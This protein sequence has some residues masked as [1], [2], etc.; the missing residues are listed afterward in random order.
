MALNITLLG[1][2]I[3]AEMNLVSENDI[4]LSATNT[5]NLLNNKQSTIT[6]SLEDITTSNLSS[7]RPIVT[8][9]SSKFQGSNFNS[10]LLENLNNVSTSIQSQIDEKLNI[11]TGAISSIVNNSLTGNKI[12]VS[13]GGKI[14]VSTIDK[15]KFDFLSSINSNIKTQIEIRT[16]LLNNINNL[17]IDS[18]NNIVQNLPPTGI[19]SIVNLSSIP[20]PYIF[21]KKKLNSLRLQFEAQQSL[22]SDDINKLI[23]SIEITNNGITS[24][25]NLSTS[26]IVIDRGNKTIDFNYTPNNNLQY[27]ISI[28]L[29]K[30]DLSGNNGE[31]LNTNYNISVLP[32]QIFEF[33]IL[34]GTTKNI[35]TEITLGETIEI[36]SSFSYI[37]GTDLNI[38][39]VVNDGSEINPVINFSN[40][41]ANQFI[42]RFVVANDAIHSCTLTIEYFGFTCD[43]TWTSIG[44]SITDNDIYSF[45][46]TFTYDGTLNGY[47]TG[48][49]MKINNENTLILTFLGGDKL[50]NSNIANQINNISYKTGS[51]GSITNVL[52]S[53]IETID[54]VAESIKINKIIPDTNDDV[55]IYVTLIA[56]D[57]TI[58]SSPL[59]IIIPNTELAP[60]IYTAHMF[61]LWDNDWDNDGVLNSNSIIQWSSSHVANY[62]LGYHSY[63]NGAAHSN[64]AGGMG[65]RDMFVDGHTTYGVRHNNTWETT[66]YTVPGTGIV[67]KLP[68]QREGIGPYIQYWYFYLAPSFITNTYHSSAPGSWA[69]TATS[70]SDGDSSINMLYMIQC[71]DSNMGTQPGMWIFHRSG[72]QIGDVRITRNTKQSW[73]LEHF[74]TDQTNGVS[75][76]DWVYGTNADKNK[77]YAFQIGYLNSSK[78]SCVFSG[79]E[80]PLVD[81]Y[82]YIFEIRHL[83]T[84]NHSTGRHTGTVL[85]VGIR[86]WDGTNWN[87]VNTKTCKFEFSNALEGA[88]NLGNQPGYPTASY[89]A[90][91]SWMAHLVSDHTWTSERTKVYNLLTN[92]YTNTSLTSSQLSW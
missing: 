39:G 74:T 5:Q 14:D 25:I 87:K 86:Y 27:D 10:N 60:D 19:L 70:S 46:T 82:L 26:G 90:P 4:T 45:P 9:S 59:I 79:A 55:Y 50:H 34:Q 61:Y 40:K 18:N 43:Y 53:D 81:G 69:T 63:L 8:G 17:V 54:P 44:F 56:P 62:N 64:A 30:L 31:I 36:I 49:H 88:I 67:Y 68:K 37:L 42:Y 71:N 24:N 80:V 35:N 41:S 57:S 32:S 78:H 47:D 52:N 22:F 33:P 89:M 58:M 6:G 3:K 75:I 29:K 12:L 85:E 15:S 76:E 38:T 48:L 23:H 73:G 13:N 2:A 91:I 84:V 72:G 66:T 51:N 11:P 65:V 7:S 28:K 77:E 16:N 20:V 1:N 21:V 92:R 83:T